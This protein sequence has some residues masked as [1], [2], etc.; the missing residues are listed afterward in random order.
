[1]PNNS[2]YSGIPLFLIYL[3]DIHNREALE[4]PQVQTVN[5][6]VSWQ[7]CSYECV[8]LHSVLLT[9]TYSLVANIKTIIIVLPFNTISKYLSII[10]WVK[11]SVNPPH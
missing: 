9:D 2:V 3:P 10:Q 11:R 8:T 1:M 4:V 5:V 6:T 7:A